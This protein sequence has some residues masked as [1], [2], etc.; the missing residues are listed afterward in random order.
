[1]QTFKWEEFASDGVLDRVRIASGLPASTTVGHLRPLVSSI[2]SVVGGL[3]IV[4][5]ALSAEQ[6]DAWADRILDEALRHT[7]SRLSVPPLN[8]GFVLRTTSNRVFESELLA[9]ATVPV[10]RA[11]KAELEALPVIGPAVA[12]KIVADRLKAGRFTAMA[13]FV[14]RIQGIGEQGAKDLSH[15]LRFDRVEDLDDEMLMSGGDFDANLKK[16]MSVQPGTTTIGRLEG[17]LEAIAVTC[18]SDRHPYEAAG[19]QVPIPSQSAAPALPIADVRLLWGAA[20]YAALVPL[21]LAATTSID[22]CMF[23]IAMAPGSH[24]T[25]TLLDALVA[26]KNRG[27][28]VRVLMDADRARDPYLSTVINSAAKEL[29]EAAGVSVRFDSPETLLHSKFI[30][31]DKRIVII[32]SHN[33]S[34]GSYFQFD[35]LSVLMASPALATTQADRFAALW[36]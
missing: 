27:V 11:S 26:A 36:G 19:L 28:L 17:A 2:L 7:L 8:L 14:R 9:L 30:V 31:I 13:D 1:M 33:W 20:Y 18:A 12:A 10:N 6:Q 16:L 22:V 35:D 32:G 25:R 4:S 24:P 3:P 15:A 29:L 21:F 34:A 23:H 5:Q